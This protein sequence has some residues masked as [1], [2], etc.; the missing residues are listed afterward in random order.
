MQ[1]T[2]TKGAFQDSRAEVVVL[3]IFAV[4]GEMTAPKELPAALRTRFLKLA[5][6]Q[7]FMGKTG[8]TLALPAATG[9]VE[10]V[11]LVGLG[12]RRGDVA[13]AL[14][15]GAGATIA[16]ATGLGAR[17]VT[18]VLP[19]RELWKPERINAW[20]MGTLL[21]DYR[22]DQYKKKKDRRVGE[23]ELLIPD[24]RAVAA[25]R[26]VLE[27][28]VAIGDG[29]T[30]ARDLVNLP[31]GEM[32]PTRLAAAA[33]EIAKASDGAVAVKILSRAD[34]QKLG[35]GAYLAVAAG[36]D[37]E[38]KFIH[39]TYTPARPSRRSVAIIGK[40]VTFDSGG[41]SLKPSDGM[42]TMKCDMAG[43]AAVL[44]LMAAL[45][46]LK[47]R[48]V[49][50]GI[51]AAVEN[52]PSGKAYRPGDVV[53]SMAGTTIEVLN[54]DAEGRLTLADALAYVRKMVPDAE[55]VVDLA[56]LTGACMVG[57]GEAI[58]ALMTNDHALGKR[59][60]TAARG[61]GEKLWELPLE[62]SYRESLRSDVADLKN[63]T[64]SRYGG[65]I[66]AGLFLSE[67]AKGLPWAHLDIAGPAFAEKPL[68]TYIGKG[69]TG[70]GVRT[71]AEFLKE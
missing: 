57:L 7:E 39:M 14:R 24:G 58:A 18:T 33:T 17:T 32:T 40:G 22:F 47:P 59:L 70:Y 19:T 3:P 38:P 16:A 15:V 63:I 12:E 53:K 68:A 55:A 67:F 29:V 25:L 31:A 61:S 28:T 44:G 10:M 5:K 11:L 71:L 43:G 30:V 52:M 66:T 46:R 6:A 8:Q 60:L 2:L 41:L 9:D 50:H 56:T 27:H 36:S 34:C 69:A 37:E 45:P 62:E 23:M 1:L 54:T 65:A 42:M 4:D 26:R 49:V 35:M 13:E 64:N 20:A 48:V 51:V 21:A